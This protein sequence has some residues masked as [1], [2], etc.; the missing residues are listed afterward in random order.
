[1]RQPQQT[2]RCQ[3]SKKRLLMLHL[4]DTQQTSNRAIHLL[5]RVYTTYCISLEIS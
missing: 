3:I 1:M 5:P 4:E 2:M